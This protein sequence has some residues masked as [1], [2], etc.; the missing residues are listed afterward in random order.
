LLRFFSVF[1]PSTVSPFTPLFFPFNLHLSL[2]VELS[3]QN[4]LL[5][6]FFLFFCG[7]FICSTSGP[8]T[9][10]RSVKTGVLRPALRISFPDQTVFSP[11]WF[12][13]PFVFSHPTCN[14]KLTRGHP[15]P[16]IPW[17][18]SPPLF[19]FIPPCWWGSPTHF[20]APT[21]VALSQQ[22]PRRTLRWAPDEVRS[23]RPRPDA[24]LFFFW[25]FC[26]IFPHQRAP[27]F[28][29]LEFKSYP[30]FS[31]WSHTSPRGRAFFLCSACAQVPF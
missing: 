9:L 30:L 29:F 12:H 31:M 26:F 17:K 4:P 7:T 1:V 19:I 23:T 2:G 27:W 22:F 20:F 16:R 25:S 18:S 3:D 28:S 10:E 11:N 14:G 6:L 13:F 8:P 24:P 15:P 21:C 5:T